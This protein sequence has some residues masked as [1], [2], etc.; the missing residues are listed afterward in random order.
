MYI[1]CPKCSTSYNVDGSNIGP[2]GRAVRCFNCSHSWRQLP[3]AARP[4]QDPSYASYAAQHHQLPMPP[5]YYP[6]GPYHD[7]QAYGQ[8]AG[9]PLQNHQTRPQYPGSGRPSDLADA[10]PMNTSDQYID[11]ASTSHS[12]LIKRLDP[13][14]GFKDIPLTEP[15]EDIKPEPDDGDLPSEEE[16]DAMFGDVDS[17]PSLEPEADDNLAD[18][19]EEELETLEDPLPL[20]TLAQGP[21]ETSSAEEIEPDNIPDPEPIPMAFP[22]EDEPHKKRGGKGLIIFGVIIV[23]LASIFAGG[24]IMRETVV[25]YLSGA[26]TVYSMIGL[27]VPQAGDGL[28]LRFSEPR[29][30][31]KLEDKIIIDLVVENITDE[32]LPVPDV[33]TKATDAD[34]NV[35]QEITT[36]PSKRT[37]KPGE[38]IRFKAVFKKV[39]PTAKD[40]SVPV[41]AEI[42]KPDG[43]EKK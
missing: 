29:R 22:A 13:D 8:Q 18:A 2:T 19:D 23:L 38:V 1:T 42:K 3:V 32:S 28:D 17:V 35:V 24:V 10:E 11:P 41:W 36:Q 15:D 16:L 37:V 9:Y 21:E 20:E 43:Q 25:S 27:R 6:Q 12:D 31:E 40:I 4:V 26:N 30:D 39:V 33:I 34:G 7:L 14:S 5:Q